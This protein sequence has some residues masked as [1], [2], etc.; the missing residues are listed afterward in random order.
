MAL[1]VLRP[2]T[3]QPPNPNTV[4]RVATAL[5]HIS[6]IEMPDPITNAAMGSEDFRI[7]WHGNTAALKPLRQGQSTNL[8]IWTEHGQSSDEIFAPA[9]VATAAFV[10]DQT[11][12]RPTPAKQAEAHIKVSETEI[13]KAA[14]VL[15]TQ[16]M[17]QSAPVN[18][19]GVKDAKDHVNVRISEIV[20]DK[21]LVARRR[22]RT[23]ADPVC[24][25]ERECQRAGGDCAWTHAASGPPSDDRQAVRGG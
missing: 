20:R 12:G 15:I 2:F 10:I 14:D 21:A 8:F 17:L 16:T 6:L 7:E 1:S 5:N 3:H 24:V 25:L 18:S 13:Q 23:E 19:R 22:D 4:T 9:E 11:E